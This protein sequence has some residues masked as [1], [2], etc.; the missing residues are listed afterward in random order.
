MKRS[1]KIKK[2]HWKLLEK[3]IKEDNIEE[4]QSL[5]DL[6]PNLINARL[7]HLGFISDRGGETP[8]HLAYGHEKIAELL[9]AKDPELLMIADENNHHPLALAASGGH[10]KVVELLIAKNP[11]VLDYWGETAMRSAA[12]RGREKIVEILAKAKEDKDDQEKIHKLLSAQLQNEKNVNIELLDLSNATKNSISV[13][14]L[15]DYV[16]SAIKGNKT[17]AIALHLH[18]KAWASLVIKHIGDNN[19]QLIYNDPT[20]N[21]FSKEPAVRELINSL[22]EQNQ[23]GDTTAT[24]LRK[25]QQIIESDSG[26]IIVDNLVKLATS[27]SLKKTDLQK[28]LLEVEQVKELKVKHLLIEETGTIYSDYKL[29][30]LLELSLTDKPVFIA[31]AT[32]F[33][34]KDLLIENT[35][36]AVRQVMSNGTPVIMPLNAQGKNRFE[37]KLIKCWSG[38]VIKKLLDGSLQ[39]ICSNPTGDSFKIEKNSMKLMKTILELTSEVQIID[40]VYEQDLFKH[41]S[42]L[43][44]VNNLVKLALSDTNNFHIKD[45]Q[46]LLSEEVGK[47]G[48]QLR[49]QHDKLIHNYVMPN[50]PPEAELSVLAI[51]GG[52]HEP[53]EH[54]GDSSESKEGHMAPPPYEEDPAIQMH[55]LGEGGDY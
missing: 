26:A 38:V 12:A 36:V 32:A 52:E 17:L 45:F 43:F 21:A 19:L 8:L 31:P 22:T 10:E 24:D 33:E 48:Y 39:V 25:I 34:D 44:T 55:V 54:K 53:F 40:I 9:I 13:Q 15:Q 50:L 23:N 20:G 47:N 51:K 11:K 4:V 28:L 49:Q 2:S 1:L 27:K 29:T 3:A 46:K 42:G 6:Y 18:G 5:L 37:T 14:Q 30:K 35:K 7:D 16:D 41:G